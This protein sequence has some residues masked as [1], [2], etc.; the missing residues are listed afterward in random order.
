MAWLT[1]VLEGVANV[2]TWGL[3]SVGKSALSGPK[4][5][6]ENELIRR[7]QQSEEERLRAQ[8]DQERRKRRTALGIGGGQRSLLFGDYSG[9]GR[10]AMLGSASTPL[11]TQA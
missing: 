7:K 5:N 1:D 9:S 8:Q 4:E 11:G 10:P 3:Y 6:P 2:Y